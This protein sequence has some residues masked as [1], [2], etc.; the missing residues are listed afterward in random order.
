MD[1]ITV[2]ASEGLR[3]PR[4]DN[5]RTYITESEAVSVPASTYYLRRIAEGDLVQVESVPDESPEQPKPNKSS[6]SKG[7]Q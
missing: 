3:V 6:K 7:E 4:E 2:K 1:T 5:H